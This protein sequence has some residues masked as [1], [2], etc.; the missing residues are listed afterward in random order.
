MA[1]NVAVTAGS[2]TTIAADEVTD[3][4]LGTVKVQ[5][6]KLMDG[7][8]DGTAKAKI[9]AAS[10]APVATDP[11]LVVSISPNSVNANGQATMANSAPVVIAS[12]QSVLP[13]G[14]A[15]A[16]AVPANAV[17]DGGNASTALA[18]AATAGNLV[19]AMFDKFGR[20]VVLPGTI[21]DL[22]GTQTTTISA[23]TSEATIV[24]AGASGVFNDLIALII[25]NTSAS[26][27]TRIDIRD[28]TAG[29]I[30]FSLESIGGAAPVGIPFMGVPIPQTTAANNWTAQCAT[31]TTDVRV[32]AVFAKNK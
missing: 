22:V 13:V 18:S 23:S 14:G 31:S 11:A 30:I 4:T 27:N 9:L 8:L 25:S 12:N 21:R 29:S 10:T 20:Q 26:T 5:Y 6:V 15:T 17:Y 7:T 24:T 1:D 32:L 2:G 16:A 19:G 28:A 3:G